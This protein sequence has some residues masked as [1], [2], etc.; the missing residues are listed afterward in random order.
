MV[1]G[2]CQL[3]PGRAINKWN[4]ETREGVG[5]PATSGGSRWL[6][7]WHLHRVTTL[8]LSLVLLGQ[9]HEDSHVLVLGHAL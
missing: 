1:H 7:L 8:E 9:G 2:C 5:T 3:L 4:E 6:A